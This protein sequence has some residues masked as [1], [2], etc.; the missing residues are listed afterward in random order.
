MKKLIILSALLLSFNG[1]GEYQNP[2]TTEQN[3]WMD[4]CSTISE[5]KE[6][7]FN[8]WDEY[9]E[10]S[11]PI[12]REYN[13]Q[14][15]CFSNGKKIIDIDDVYVR[16]YDRNSISYDTKNG[17]GEINPIRPDVTCH[18]SFQEGWFN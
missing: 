10:S 13:Q 15:E 4:D 5:E 12:S 14:I 8:A 7:P 16:S 3:P 2:C 6:N 17:W 18:I 9:F 1:W 11:E